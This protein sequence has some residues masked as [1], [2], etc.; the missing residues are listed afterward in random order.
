MYH[1]HPVASSEQTLLCK[2]IYGNPWDR[3]L[4][5]GGAWVTES[6]LLN[7][8]REI[9]AVTTQSS[10]NGGYVDPNMEEQTV[11]LELFSGP[12]VSHAWPQRTC[13]PLWQWLTFGV[14]PCCIYQLCRCTSEGTVFG[15]ATCPYKHTLPHEGPGPLQYHHHMAFIYPIWNQAVRDYNCGVS[16]MSKWH[17]QVLAHERCLDFCKPWWF[18]GDVE[19][20]RK[21]RNQTWGE[22]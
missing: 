11:C 13:Q 6:V 18:H 8:S 14:C 19:L 1:W 3:R 9:S 15:A 7:L 2:S 12:W 16:G 10:D 21:G 17:W 4:R 5:K 20:K 22:G